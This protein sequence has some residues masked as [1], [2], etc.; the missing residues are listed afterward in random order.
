VNQG[1][2]PEVARR[3][4]RSDDEQPPSTTTT[5]VQGESVSGRSIDVTELAAK[6][7]DED[8]RA[9]QAL[10]EYFTIL[11]QWALDSRPDDGLAP[12]S[13]TEEP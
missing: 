6:V 7:L 2:L 4:R 10:A 3:P 9:R 13:K 1:A 12:D 8:P 11:R 5:V